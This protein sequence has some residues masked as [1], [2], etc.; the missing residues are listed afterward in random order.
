MGEDSGH[1]DFAQGG[2]GGV[3]E[4]RGHSIRFGLS[5]DLV[6]S[7]VETIRHHGA[8]T[9]ILLF[10]SRTRGDHSRRSDIDV[11]IEGCADPLLIRG[12]L[13]EEVPTLC[14]FDVVHLGDL[15]PEMTRSIEQEGVVLYDEADEPA[16]DL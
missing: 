7:I 4:D 6:R 15:G 2:Q 5:D 16:L 14:R 11:A 3:A 8:P 12:Y 13:E 10:G 1:S 9:R